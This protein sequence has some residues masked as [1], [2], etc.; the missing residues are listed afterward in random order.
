[1]QPWPIGKPGKSFRER[2]AN[3]RAQQGELER[4][5]TELDLD[6]RTFRLIEK[7]QDERDIMQADLIAFKDALDA[8]PEEK[9]DAWWWAKRK[10]RPITNVVIENCVVEKPPSPKKE[11]KL[12]KP[13]VNYVVEKPPKE[14]DPAEDE[15]SW[16]VQPVD[17]THG[18]G[19]RPCS[20]CQE[21]EGVKHIRGPWSMQWTRPKRGRPWSIK[22]KHEDSPIR[23]NK[24]PEHDNYVVEKAEPSRRGSR[25]LE[26][27]TGPEFP[28]KEGAV[29]EHS[30]QEE[31]QSQNGATPVLDRAASP[32]VPAAEGVLPILSPDKEASV[33]AERRAVRERERLYTDS[34]WICLDSRDGPTGLDVTGASWHMLDTGVIRRDVESDPPRRPRRH[35]RS[36]SARPSVKKSATVPRVFFREIRPKQKVVA[37]AER[38]ERTE[39]D[40][41]LEVQQEA[42]AHEVGSHLVNWSTDPDEWLRNLETKILE[43]LDRS[44]TSWAWIRPPPS[45]PTVLRPEVPDEPSKP[46]H[47]FASF[48][49]KDED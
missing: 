12:Q 39:R 34:P 4:L 23:S 43:D 46:R 32:S 47:V 3:I 49:S 5:R 19:G 22:P 33:L 6:V 37:Q 44:P 36:Q 18:R 13:V 7:Q 25:K 17:C 9:L 2:R 10:S 24:F 40:I 27:G 45:P 29:V 14:P 30:R 21:L 28:E 48:S 8:L 16:N 15:D 20:L 41:A 31:E 35:A 38:H 1:M 26:A 42:V 11:P